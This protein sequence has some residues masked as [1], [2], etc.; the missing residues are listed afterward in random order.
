VTL[1]NVCS[2]A[3]LQKEVTSPFLLCHKK[4]KAC[5]YRAQVL[6]SGVWAMAT[7][8]ET[9]KQ[10][11]LAHHDALKGAR[12]AIIVIDVAPPPPA[13]KTLKCRAK[14]MAGTPCPFRATKGCFC[15]RHSI[16]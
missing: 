2:E 12:R 14:T 1:S 5:L 7:K 9:S 15:S 13:I 4:E 16:K 10:R 6:E 11:F 3:L 8:V